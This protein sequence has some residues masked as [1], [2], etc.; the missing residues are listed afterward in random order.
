MIHTHFIISYEDTGGKASELFYYGS[1]SEGALL[2]F[3]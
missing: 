3:H 2:M 1:K